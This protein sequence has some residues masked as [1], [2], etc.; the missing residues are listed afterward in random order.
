MTNIDRS[1]DEAR[2]RSLIDERA[3]AL[4]AKDAG[5]L[6]AHAAPDLVA[7]T[8]APPLQNPRP[9]DRR[10]LDEWFA[11]W[12]DDLALEARDMRIEVGGDIAFA[13]GLVRMSGTKVDGERPDLWARQTLC[14][15]RI[16]GVWKVAHEHTSVPFYMDGSYRAAVDL[17]P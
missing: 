13:H 4:G 8:L 12:R 7:F 2:I 1:H 6:L 10:G 17:K 15:R 14:L 16:D 11:T 3:R 5:A 9:L